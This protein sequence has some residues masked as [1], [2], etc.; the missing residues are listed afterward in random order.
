M[1][2]G[3]LGQIIGAFRDCGS[4]H[5]RSGCM[6]EAMGF[7]KRAQWSDPQNVRAHWYRGVFYEDVAMDTE[8][9]EDFYLQAA[10]WCVRLSGRNPLSQLFV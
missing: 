9:A 7:Y 2:A 3:P 1:D 5:C 8:A 10:K 6:E 4:L